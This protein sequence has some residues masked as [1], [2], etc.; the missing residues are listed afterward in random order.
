MAKAISSTVDLVNVVIS[1][2]VNSFNF[3]MCPSA[4]KCF[5]IQQVP[6]SDGWQRTW[7]Q[8][9]PMMPGLRSSSIL[10][11]KQNPHDGT[12]LESFQ[13]IGGVGT[14]CVEAH[15]A[16]NMIC[17]VWSLISEIKT[18]SALEDINTSNNKVLKD[19]ESI[20]VVG[21]WKLGNLTCE[22]VKS[23]VMVK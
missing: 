21:S 14:A 9:I 22:T 7:W 16:S 23:S 2:C 11:G 17:K 15:Q 6:C 20:I 12:C 19:F 18:Y 1:D 10:Q 3:G 4:S 8:I 5:P 13:A